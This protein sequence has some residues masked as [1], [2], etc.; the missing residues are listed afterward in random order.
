MLGCG[1]W[2]C[3]AGFG[4]AEAGRKG[5][6]RLMATLVRFSPSHQELA[7]FSQDRTGDLPRC[8]ESPGWGWGAGS[9]KRESWIS[10]LTPPGQKRKLDLGRGRVIPAG[11]DTAPPR[12]L[13]QVPRGPGLPPRLTSVHTCAWQGRGLE[14]S[15]STTRDRQG[16]GPLPVATQAGSSTPPGSRGPKPG[17]G[18]GH[19][20]RSNDDA[21]SRL[22]GPKGFH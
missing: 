19:P 14:L 4:G 7:W 21:S 2:K 16:N 8:F 5:A 11:T 12:P 18:S 15:Q 9:G 1:V 20:Q 6:R 13:R 10:F 3:L 17:L 22:L